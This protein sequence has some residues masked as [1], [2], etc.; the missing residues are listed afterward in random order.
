MLYFVLVFG[1]FC[2]AGKAERVGKLW[3][4]EQEFVSGCVKIKMDSKPAYFQGKLK[5]Y[6]QLELR[7]GVSKIVYLLKQWFST[8]GS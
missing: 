4:N 7:I 3:K 8:F 6:L 2:C 1:W 5:F